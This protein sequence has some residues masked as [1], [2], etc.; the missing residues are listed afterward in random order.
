MS[1]TLDIVKAWATGLGPASCPRTTKR[2]RA[3][4][5]Y[6]VLTLNGAK[7]RRVALP[8]PLIR[9]PMT[10]TR[11]AAKKRRNAPS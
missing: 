3:S 4:Q 2:P 11:L 10:R 8:L 6:F 7:T 9:N 1:V 5:R